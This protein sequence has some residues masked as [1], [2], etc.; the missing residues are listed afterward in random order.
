MSVGALYSCGSNFYNVT[1]VAE[2][3]ELSFVLTTPC[4][5]NEIFRRFEEVVTCNT[6]SF[7]SVPALC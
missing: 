6:G 2:Y 5:T 3:S 7:C 1:C 4:T